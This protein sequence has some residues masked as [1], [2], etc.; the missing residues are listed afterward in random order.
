MDLKQRLT[1]VGENPLPLEVQIRSLLQLLCLLIR[2]LLVLFPFCCLSSFF[3]FSFSLFLSSFPPNKFDFG[4]EYLSRCRT[5][6]LS[7]LMTHS[8]PHVIHSHFP[9]TILSC[10]IEVCHLASTQVP[11]DLSSGVTWHEFHATCHPLI[12]PFVSKYVQFRPSRNSTKFEYV[13]RFR[14]TNSTVYP[15]SSSEI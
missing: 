2:E 4:G 14:E 6:F 7:L 15:A 1:R 12:C 8:I 3:S 13:L 5:P 10:K 9:T 11:S